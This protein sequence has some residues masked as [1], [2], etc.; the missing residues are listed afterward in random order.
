MPRGVECA[1]RDSVAGRRSLL[2]VPEGADETPR[3]IWMHG[4]AYCYNSPRAY[5]TLVAHVAKAVGASILLPSYRLAPEHPY[6]AG[7]QDTLA[8]YRAIR[9]QGKR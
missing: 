2:V 5:A 1:Q 6:P 7:H 8:A 4:G 3:V 9:D